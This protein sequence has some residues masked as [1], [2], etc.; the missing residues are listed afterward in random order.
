[1][2]KTKVEQDIDKYAI[3]NIAR[4][5]FYAWSS[6]E[7]NDHRSFKHCINQAEHIYKIQQEYMNEKK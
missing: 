6:H 7:D 3:L 4:E 2:A 1:M 5:I